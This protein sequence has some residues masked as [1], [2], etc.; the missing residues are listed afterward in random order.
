MTVRVRSVDAVIVYAGTSDELAAIADGY[1]RGD[2]PMP[3]GYDQSYFRRAATA[4]RA[5]HCP[6][7]DLGAVRFYADRGDG[8]PFRG[9]FAPKPDPEWAARQP[10][11]ARVG[12]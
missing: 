11:A 9:P 4:L 7:Y 3:R 5:G 1:A 2:R 12:V 6:A 10:R 8:T